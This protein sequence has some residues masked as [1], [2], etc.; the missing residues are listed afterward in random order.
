MSVSPATDSRNSAT[1]TILDVT[2]TVWRE[3]QILWLDLIFDRTR[4][5]DRLL[6]A[7]N[8]LKYQVL[9]LP[10]SKPDK[11]FCVRVVTPFRAFEDLL[12]TILELFPGSDKLLDQKI[13]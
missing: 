11:R 3:R 8:Q 10:P 7:V 4:S 9:E 5:K 13:K 2:Q 1:P 6:N 12:F